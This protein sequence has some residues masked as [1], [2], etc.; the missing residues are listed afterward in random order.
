MAGINQNEEGKRK[1]RPEEDSGK[2]TGE[3]MQEQRFDQPRRGYQTIGDSPVPHLVQVVVE[4]SRR[5][6]QDHKE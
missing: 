2:I 5:E 4:K 1:S 6:G 3:P